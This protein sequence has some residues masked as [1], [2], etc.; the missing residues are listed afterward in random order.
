MEDRYVKILGYLS[1]HGIEQQ[2][3]TREYIIE[4]F[5]KIKIGE[6][7]AYLE[8]MVLNRHIRF[9]YNAFDEYPTPLICAITLEGSEYL[10]SYY[11]K[12]ATLQ[13]F[14]NQ[15]W[16]NR[17]TWFISCVSIG[18]AVFFGLKSSSLS[19]QVEVMQK[20]LNTIEKKASTKYNRIPTVPD[21]SKKT[22]P[23]K[24]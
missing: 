5:K 6:A 3:D 2:V 19:S 14:K 13:S 4:I 7:H 11:L 22:L 21:T 16:V 20:R 12:E 8:H 17:I 23:K 9:N 18:I 15:K 24:P 10:T 1:I